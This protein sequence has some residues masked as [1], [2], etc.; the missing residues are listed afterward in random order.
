[1]FFV[2]SKIVYFF[3]QPF[4]WLGVVLICYLF[5]KSKRVKTRLKFT[6]LFLFFFFSNTAILKT[7]LHLWEIPAKELV[8]VKKHDVA[9][10][11]GGMFEWDNDVKRLSARRGSDRIWQTF[12]LYKAKKINKILISGASGYVVD[13]GLHEAIQLKQD[14]IQMGIPEKDLIV[15]T[16]SR[17]THENAKFSVALLKQS[18]PHLENVLLV[19]SARHMRRAEACFS[20]EGLICTA[21]ST[22]QYTGNELSFN[23]DEFF[24]PNA[25]TMSEWTELIKE[26]VGYLV[27][28]VVGFI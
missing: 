22:D 25:D 15:E 7:V 5:T 13:R 27:Y 9:L 4:V 1:M 24:I 2:F 6:L 20:K 19:T 23:W 8:Q 3:L 11:L 21:F 18:Y 28:D 17:N 12:K 10:V 14:L 26:V 16:K